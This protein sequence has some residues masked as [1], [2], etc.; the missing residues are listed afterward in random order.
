MAVTGD[1]ALA[2]YRFKKGDYVRC[3]TEDAAVRYRKPHL[4]T[5]GYLFGVVGIVDMVRV[6][7]QLQLMRLASTWTPS[8]SSGWHPLCSVL[9]ATWLHAGAE[10]VCPTLPPPCTPAGLPGV[11][12]DS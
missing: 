9:L 5:P 4:R 3:K 10:G 7:Q 2:F 1:Q 8:S 11:P 12:R 6:L